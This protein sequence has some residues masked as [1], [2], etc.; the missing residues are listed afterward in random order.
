M[1]GGEMAG[2]ALMR[3]LEIIRRLDV[4]ELRQVQQAVQERL[5]QQD[6]AAGREAFHHALLASGL[7]KE[8]KTRVAREDQEQALVPIQGQPLSKTIIEERR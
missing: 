5:R 4:A 8:I 2:T 1:E 3:A 6:E 7:V